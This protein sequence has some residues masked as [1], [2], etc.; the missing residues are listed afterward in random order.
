MVTESH[1]YTEVIK[2][3]RKLEEGEQGRDYQPNHTLLVVRAQKAKTFRL[4]PSILNDV[5][6]LVS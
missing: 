4:S 5:V 6:S 3:I 2:G 1:I